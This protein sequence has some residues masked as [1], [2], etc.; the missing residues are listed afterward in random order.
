MK[1]KE[2]LPN[3]DV[4]IMVRTN[5]PPQFIGDTLY[6]YCRW[7]GK[8]LES[9]DGDSYDLDWE[10]TKFVWEDEIHLVIWFE[11]EWW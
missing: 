8:N 9:L 6:G 10:V 7:D 11:T 5:L 3:R 2:I 1:L 4:D